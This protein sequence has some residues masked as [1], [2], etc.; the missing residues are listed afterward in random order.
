M[1]Q[2]HDDPLRREK[3]KDSRHFSFSLYL[4]WR[5]GGHEMFVENPQ[6]LFIGQVELEDSIATQPSFLNSFYIPN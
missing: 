1:S 6:L 2:P 4:Q 3:Q 5:E